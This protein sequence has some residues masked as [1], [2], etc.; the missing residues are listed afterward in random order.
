MALFSITTTANAQVG[1]GCHAELQENTN[2]HGHWG[3]DTEETPFAE[4]GGRTLR[5][6]NDKGLAVADLGALAG[7]VSWVWVDAEDCPNSALTL[8]TGKNFTG[9]SLVLRYTATLTKIDGWN[10]RAQSARLGPTPYDCEASYSEHTDSNGET[11][12]FNNG[13]GGGRNTE[14]NSLRGVSSGDFWEEISSLRFSG[15]CWGSQI[16]LYDQEYF[17]GQVFVADANSPDAY[18]ETT[19]YSVWNRLSEHGWNDRAQSVKI[20]IN[21]APVVQLTGDPVVTLT[22]GDVFVDEGAGALDNHD[23][24]I[25]VQ[26]IGTV[27]T[28]TPGVYSL[29]YFAQDQHGKRGDAYRTVR[30][31]RPSTFE[32]PGESTLP[33]DFAIEADVNIDW[34]ESGGSI[35]EIG[36]P[37]YGNQALLRLQAGKEGRWWISVG[38]GADASDEYF[39]GHWTFGTPFRLMVTYDHHRGHASVYENGE[40]VLTYSPVP[41]PS[42]R[43]GTV[44]LGSDGAAARGFIAQVTDFQISALPW[45]EQ[46]NML[47]A[48][49]GVGAD[50]TVRIV[51][52]TG[53]IFTQ[54]GTG[55]GW[56]ENHNLGGGVRIAVDPSGMAWAVTENGNIFR[57]IDTSTGWQEQYNALARD[58]GVGADGTV[59]IV[60]PTGQIFT[61]TTSGWQEN[62]NLGGGA[63][64]AVDPSGMAWVVTENGNIFRQ[65]DTSTGWQE[66]YNALARDIAVGPDGQVW[67]VS[68]DGKVYVKDAD[69]NE[70]AIGPRTAA[71]I[72]LDE[73]S[74]P[75]V[76]MDDGA[77]F[78][79]V[80]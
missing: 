11:Q 52:P 26:V 78:R 4:K 48:D 59:K 43:S 29:H 22:V 1:D 53:Q 77:I 30:V 45:Q 46:F 40:R 33:T 15:E 58:I 60:T 66:Q 8:Y 69:W 41:V 3:G 37:D 47:A 75:W 6:D 50:G 42:G 35:I 76:V 9:E 13:Q 27:D 73:N 7:E 65:I 18:H 64:I 79:Y 38:D 20:D 24:R 71:S 32:T 39:E 25:D 68:K 80:P 56:A 55:S 70:V 16:L 67:I 19:R 23:G 72:T 17:G 51:S 14:H 54:T 62:H 49:I 10:D 31:I 36:F 28:N 5:L 74:H 61:Q 21:T 34:S 2:L 63:R 44:V 57:Q 12:T